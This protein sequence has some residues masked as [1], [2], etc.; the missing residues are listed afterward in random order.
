MDNRRIKRGLVLIPLLVLALAAVAPNAAY[1]DTLSELY[2]DQ[3]DRMKVFVGEDSSGNSD[4]A[5]YA[6]LSSDQ[7]DIATYSDQTVSPRY[8]TGE[9]LYF[10][11]WES[12]Q[13]YDQGLSYGDGYHALGYFQFDNRYDL[14]SFLQAVY[15]YNP[16]KYGVLAVIGSNYGWN[17]AGSTRSNGAFTQLGNDLNYVWHAC[18]NVDPNEFSQ[19]Q[20]G[21][22]YDHYYLPAANYMRSRGIP[23]DNRSESVKSLCWGM[24]NLFGTGGWRKFVGGVTSGYDWDGNWNN[25]RDWPGAGLNASMSDYEFISTLCDYVINNVSVFYKAQPQYW[26]GWQNRYRDEKAHYL[27]MIFDDGRQHIVA[28]AHVAWIGWMPKVSDGAVAGTTGKGYGLEDLRL[29]LVGAECP[30]SVEVNA[31]VSNLGWQGWDTP[32][33]SEGG[34]TGQSRQIEAL[35]IRLT[36]QMADRYDVWYRVHSAFFGWMGWAK[37]GESAGSTGYGRQV[38][39]VQ[40]VLVE[41]GGQAPS[42]E[43]QQYQASFEVKPAS[44]DCQ[45]HVA[46]IGWMPKVSDGAVAGTTGKGY[47]LEDLRLSLVGAE[48]PG[49]V[50]VNAHVSNLGWQGWDT[51]S[52]SE[53]GTTGQ[54][55]QI[56]ALQIRLTGQ[57]ADRYDVWYRVHSAFFG[58]MGWAKDGESAG[59]TGY[60]RQVEAVQ[61][62]LVEKGGQAPGSVDNPF[63][64]K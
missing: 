23:I 32:S 5:S 49:S 42:S 53:G 15:N 36:G 27:K 58:W 61:V 30:G 62:V 57:M 21:W 52:A 26:A 39:A 17:V 3:Y 31:H 2:G 1:A 60:G 25:S 38:E 7:G 56:E 11:K 54:S 43:G 29:S 19:L 59:S 55:R 40:V 22:A 37:D 48:C 34:T 20:N 46:W 16:S 47:G 12:D 8:C 24:S 35:Q 44:V 4:E 6:E 41:K 51:P 14:G 33:A 18:Y 63:Y 28:E 10:C 64:K 13:N 45:A 50:E 9:M